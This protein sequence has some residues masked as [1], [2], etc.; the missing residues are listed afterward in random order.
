M[1]C[2]SHPRE[3]AAL[4]GTTDIDDDLIGRDH[5]QRAVMATAPLLQLPQSLRWPELSNRHE[6]HAST[7]RDLCDSLRRKRYWPSP[8]GM[9]QCR[10]IGRPS[11]SNQLSV[12]S[13]VT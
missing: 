1:L 12:S 13:S 7:L 11:S 9:A 3:V 6:P 10:Q 2:N 4:D 5:G 8:T